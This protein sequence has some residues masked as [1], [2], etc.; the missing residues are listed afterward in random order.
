MLT[1]VGC[2]QTAAQVLPESIEFKTPLMAVV[3]LS[4]DCPISQ[5]YM[6]KL[7]DLQ[8]SQK[9]LVTFLAVVPGK[10]S[11]TDVHEFIREYSSELAFRQDK[12]LKLTMAIRATVTPEIFLFDGQRTLVYRGAIDNWFYELG[13]NR[14]EVTE[15]FYKD[16]VE[17]FQQNQR[18]TVRSTEAVGCLIQYPAEGHQHH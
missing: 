5:K 4:P 18:P 7:N 10:V 11:K 13:K 9:D 16:A 6:K 3:F 17:A 14:R 15:H 12:D 8:S 1:L 2:L